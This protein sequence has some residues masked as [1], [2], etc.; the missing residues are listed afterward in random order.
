MKTALFIF[1]LLFFATI[2]F[3]QKSKSCNVDLRSYPSIEMKV[4]INGYPFN[5]VLYISKDSLKSDF[6]IVIAD[7]SIKIESFCLFYNTEYGDVW[8]QLIEGDTI[9]QN[10]TA[11]KVL[12]KGEGFELSLFKLSNRN[13]FYTG[14]KLTVILL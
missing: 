11:L 8:S 14:P 3:A 1:V 4:A 7:P 6:R 13:K 2:S 5:N 12:K 10:E 9:K